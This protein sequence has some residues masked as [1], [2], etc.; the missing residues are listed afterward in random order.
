MWQRPALLLLLALL[1]Y[2][3]LRSRLGQSR[4]QHQGHLL[5]RHLVILPGLRRLRGQQSHQKG[6]VMW[7]HSQSARRPWVLCLVPTLPVI[8]PLTCIL[9]L[10]T[11]T[12][13]QGTFTL[14]AGRE[15]SWHGQ[16]ET[17]TRAGPKEHVHL[18]ICTL[19]FTC[20]SPPAKYPVAHPRAFAARS[21]AGDA[22]LYER[23]CCWT[24]RRQVDEGEVKPLWPDMFSFTQHWHVEHASTLQ[25]DWT[26][27][28]LHGGVTVQDL[29]WEV[30]GVDLEETPLPPC[31]CFFTHYTE[32]DAAEEGWP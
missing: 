17:F 31:Y 4:E 32:G 9:H 13:C 16:L 2:L 18:S 8:L 15:H 28:A 21:L 14:W 30:L 23:F 11:S 10:F 22:S 20:T 5:V 29:A 6:R 1:L 27:L 3:S 7:M 12:M 26:T 19:L 25:T 24:C